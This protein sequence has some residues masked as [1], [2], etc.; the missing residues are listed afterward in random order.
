[1]Y[2]NHPHVREALARFGGDIEAEAKIAHK[3]W[4]GRLTDAAKTPHS[5]LFDL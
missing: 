2:H 3:V 5:T 1:M 4:A